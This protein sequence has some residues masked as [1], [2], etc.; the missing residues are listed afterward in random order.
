[1]LDLGKTWAKGSYI[2]GQGT[3][4]FDTAVLSLQRCHGRWRSNHG[5]CQ[6]LGYDVTRLEAVHWRLQPKQEIH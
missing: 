3:E 5:V 6:P 4:E 1:M 2:I